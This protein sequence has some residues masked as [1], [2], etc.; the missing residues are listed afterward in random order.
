[1]RVPSH[2][3]FSILLNLI[4]KPVFGGRSLICKP[5]SYQN[6]VVDSPTSFYIDRWKTANWNQ[7]RWIRGT[8]ETYYGGYFNVVCCWSSWM[9]TAIKFYFC[10]GN[11]DKIHNLFKWKSKYCIMTLV[12]KGAWTA[13]YWYCSASYN[14]TF[15]EKCCK[16]V[17]PK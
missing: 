5:R 6:G 14:R 17:W 13:R 3:V 7:F 12:L 9:S 8:P 1:M 10:R 15:T 2:A 11:C 4:K 16:F